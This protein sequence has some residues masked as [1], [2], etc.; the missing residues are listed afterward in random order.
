MHHPGSA[1]HRPGAVF[2][3]L[4]FSSGS[5]AGRTKYLEYKVYKEYKMGKKYLYNFTYVASL[6]AL[7]KPTVWPLNKQQ[8]L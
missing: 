3:T 1:V 2:Q 5:G 6:E 4:W 7:Q 8:R